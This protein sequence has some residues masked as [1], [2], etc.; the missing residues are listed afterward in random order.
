M[1]P[2][3]TVSAHLDNVIAVAAALYRASTVDFDKWCVC[4]VKEEGRRK[5]LRGASPL[6]QLRVLEAIAAVSRHSRVVFS[7]LT[8]TFKSFQ[9]MTLGIMTMTTL[10]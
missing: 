10:R 6:S 5:T 3:G 4:C 9:I 2:R 1:N 7:G 8:I